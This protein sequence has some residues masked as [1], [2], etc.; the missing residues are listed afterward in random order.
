MNDYSILPTTGLKPLLQILFWKCSERKNI[1]EFLKF[2]KSLCKT[3][4]YSI[5]LPACSPEISTSTKNRHQKMFPV[6]VTKFA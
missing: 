4:P 2:H 1:L 6:S 3:V 5:T